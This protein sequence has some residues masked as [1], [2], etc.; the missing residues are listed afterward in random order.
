M[1]TAIN[2][3]ITEYGWKA[4][5]KS[6]SQKKLPTPSL[7]SSPTCRDLSLR[8]VR[9]TSG[10]TIC[11]LSQGHLQTELKRHQGHLHSFQKK[12]VTTSL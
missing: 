6:S 1:G 4:T 7:P 12:L 8:K 9:D 10:D 2:N 11:Q 3:P 5:G